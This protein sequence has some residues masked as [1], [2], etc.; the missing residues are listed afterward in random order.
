MDHSVPVH[1]IRRYQ[2]IVIAVSLIC[3]FG[4]LAGSRFWDQ[5]EG[6]FAGT[7]TEMYARGEWVVP[8]FNGDLFGH[9]PPWMYWMMMAGYS[10]FGVGEFGARIFSAIFGLATACLAFR[11]GTRLFNPR[12]GLIAGLVL[13]SCL[14][15]SVVARAATPDVYLVFFS[16]LALYLFAKAGFAARPG[17]AQAIASV[18]PQ[19]PAA[20]VAI[21]GVMG[22]AALVKGPIGFLF[23]MAI[24][25][26]FL[27]LL[28]SPGKN[29]AGD[30]GRLSFLQG[31]SSRWG[32][33][34]FLRTFRN[35][36]PVTA[37]CM[38]CLVAGPWYLIVGWVTGGAFHQEFFGVHHWHRFRTP[39]DNH[40]GPIYY[41]LLSILI[42][43]FPWSMYG[44]AASREWF[45]QIRQRNEHFQA[46]MFL[47][48]WVAVYLGF[49]S[50]AST[51]LPNYVVP[52]YPA[53][54][55]I[56]AVF[57]DT[58]LKRCSRQDQTAITISFAGMLMVGAGL[59][60]MP[61]LLRIP[62]NGETL[63]QH[64]KLNVSAEVLFDRLAWIG[65]PLLL[66]SGLAIALVRARRA[67]RRLFCRQRWVE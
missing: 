12:V 20:W 56:L 60:A 55:L 14:M 18:V 1:R 25:G 33:G 36:R 61:W 44:I 26:L 16:T 57:V 66:G 8:I 40:S 29:K 9:K 50:L 19:R 46:L 15:F 23:P 43:V 11:M 49:F 13:P 22:L 53:V 21:Y 38:L 54:A 37:I 24:I 5:D 32:P 4:S 7:A 28:D 10:I 58:A 59:A 65:V 17:E 6:Y 42:G 27:M 64:A 39:M 62:L 30:H 34:N 2:W 48:C 3:L 51:K 35:M 31:L 41:Y 63:L 52:A 47:G 67:D 45:R